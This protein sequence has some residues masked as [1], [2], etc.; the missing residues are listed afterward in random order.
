VNLQDV[1]SYSSNL[2]LL[3]NVVL[4]F[5]GFLKK[6]KALV[7]FWLY[8]VMML[9]IEFVSIWLFLKSEPNLFLSHFYFML[10]FICLSYFYADLFVD[11]NRIVKYLTG[12]VSVVLLSQYLIKP[13]LFYRF[14]LAEIVFT[15]LILVIYSLYY[16]FISLKKEIKYKYINLGVFTYLLSSMLIFCSGNL[17][18]ELDYSVNRYLWTF[19]SILSVIFQLLI[20]YEWY[21]NLRHKKEALVIN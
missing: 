19:N 1:L 11:K 6:E 17:I 4:Y 7:C 14:N 20:F 5:K 8:L 21:K 9:I 12:I 10:Q 16:L 13:S 3:L 15:S 18:Q 2:L